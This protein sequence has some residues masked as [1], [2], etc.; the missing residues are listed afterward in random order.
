VITAM[1]VLVAIAADLRGSRLAIFALGVLAGQ[2]S[3]GWS[4]DAFDAERDAAAGR[5][6]K[7]IVAGDISPRAVSAAAVVALVVC[8]LL[9][10]WVGP[11]T[12][13]LNLIMVAAGWAYNVGL[14]S[15]LASGPMYVIGFGAIPA[16]AAS[17]SKDH[18]GA[19]PWTLAAAALLGLGAHFANVLPD[20]ASDQVAGVRGLPQRMASAYGQLAVR[21]TALVL[22]LTASAVIVIVPGGP[23]G[24]FAVLGL[25][26]AVL[27]VFVGAR[28]SGRL[29][30]V[31]ALGV[32][33]IDVGLF[34]LRE[35]GFGS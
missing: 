34:A 6:D 16:F 4:N 12:G 3:I 1:I 32:A 30:F 5:R 15:T 22:L 13:V 33:A 20:L 8:V 26:A 18:S 23:R 27:L 2:L 11:L 35:V 7:P 31:A 17:T 9:C 19:E 29:P 21:L 10:F 25:S 24:W 14:K 28:A